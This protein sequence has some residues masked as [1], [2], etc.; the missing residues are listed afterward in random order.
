[1]IDPLEAYWA[2]AYGVTPEV[3]TVY[4]PEPLIECADGKMRTEA[5]KAAWEARIWESLRD[6]A[7]S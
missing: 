2:T 5:D 7:Q 4:A 1:M 6:A 3:D